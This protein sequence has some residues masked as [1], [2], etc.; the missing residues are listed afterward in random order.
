MKAKISVILP[1][2]NAGKYIG[3]ALRSVIDQT[4]PIHEIIVIDDGSTDSTKDI[5]SGFPVHYFYQANSGTAAALN[6]G[7]E[8]SSGDYL[9]FIDADDVWMPQRLYVQLQAFEKN[10]SLDM[11][12][13]LMQQ[14]VSPELS[15]EEKNK[16][17][18]NTAEVMI[19]I[20]KSAWLIKREAFMGV[21]VFAGGFLLEEFTDWYARSKEKK[22]NEFVV[23]EVVA[24]R[25]IHL[26]NTSRVHKD[27]KKDY[28][29]ILK[30]ALDRRRQQEQ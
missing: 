7:I 12:F 2:Y 22:L 18:V 29:R 6:A 17:E 14:F 27:L 26:S 23:Q 13:G 16:I 20:H 15:E 1:A 28:P 9:A 19:G 11:V 10:P 25:R 4:I 21:G 3:E 30:A 5:V 8:Q 24:K